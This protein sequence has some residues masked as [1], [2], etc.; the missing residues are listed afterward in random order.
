MDSKVDMIS[1][2]RS[3]RT[4][5]NCGVS[6]NKG[7]HGPPPIGPSSSNSFID[8]ATD[9]ESHASINDN[10]LCDF[11][12]QRCCRDVHRLD[13]SNIHGLDRIGLGWVRWLMH[14]IMTAYDFFSVK[15]TE[16]IV[17]NNQWL[18][19]YLILIIYTAVAL[20]AIN[21]Q[22]PLTAQMKSNSETFLMMFSPIDWTLDWI[23]LDCI[24]SVTWW[25][26]LDWIWKNG[27]MD[28]SEML[29]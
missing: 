3:D 21:M 25:I 16:T 11:V 24:G 28:I 10:D 8:Y 12:C 18:V 14:K 27:P 7:L 4:L 26:G 19:T 13:L 23:G 15:Q 17:C 2:T 20:L 5:D 9:F 29:C 6:A 22:V 1:I